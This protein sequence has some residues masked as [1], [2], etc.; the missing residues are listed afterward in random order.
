MPS[1]LTP[2]RKFLAASH[3]LSAR[4]ALSSVPSRH[5]QA[6]FPRRETSLLWACGTRPSPPVVCTRRIKS[7]VLPSCAVS[8]CFNAC[9]ATFGLKLSVQLVT[10][11]SYYAMH[12]EPKKSVERK[13]QSSTA[14][15]RG[16]VA[17]RSAVHRKVCAV[18]SGWRSASVPALNCELQHWRSPLRHAK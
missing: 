12:Q 15:G 2:S 13:L 14:H 7:Q 1:A 17:H 18:F 9:S 8:E 6:S 11:P 16:G 4:S 10:G 5:S 3:S